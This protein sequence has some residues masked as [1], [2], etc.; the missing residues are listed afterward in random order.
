MR[1]FKRDSKKFGKFPQMMSLQSARVVLK[2]EDPIW[3]KSC[4]LELHEG[5]GTRPVQL[6]STWVHQLTS[7]SAAARTVHVILCLSYQLSAFDKENKSLSAADEVFFQ[8]H[9]PS[10][11]FSNVHHLVLL[12][13][14][15]WDTAWPLLV[16]PLLQLACSQGVA[17]KA[18]IRGWCPI[19]ALMNILRSLK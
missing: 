6:F 12:R 8:W 13:C 11:F 17:C 7:N 3:A 2:M 16:L 10:L 5:E 14:C 18:D 9:K 19:S 4:G 1:Y 15:R